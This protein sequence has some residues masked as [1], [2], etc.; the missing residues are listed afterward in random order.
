MKTLIIVLLLITTFEATS[1]RQIKFDIKTKV[2]DKIAMVIFKEGVKLALD[3]SLWAKVV[4]FREDYSLW[5]DEAAYEENNDTIIY[6]V[7]FELRTPAFFGH[8]KHIKS[9]QLTDTIPMNLNKYP[10]FNS[11]EG[12][13]RIAR[14][15]QEDKF[16]SNFISNLTEEGASLAA[17]AY[18]GG[19][20]YSIT[21]NIVRFISTKFIHQYTNNDFIVLYVAGVNVAYILKEYFGR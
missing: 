1:R 3:K 17:G 15:V 6:F 10:I 14:M 19:F 4:E 12:F 8:G 2:S 16:I 21:K 18:L 5:I 11:K 9:F 7:D 20:G 13:E